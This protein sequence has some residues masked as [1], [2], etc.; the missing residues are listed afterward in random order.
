MKR[1]KQFIRIRGI[2]HSFNSIYNEINEYNTTFWS[3]FLFIFWLTFGSLDVLILYLFCFA[4]FPIIIKLFFFYSFVFFGLCFLFVIFTASSVNYTAN[5]THK[6]LNSF[7]ISYSQY[8]RNHNF[9]EIS[10]KLKVILF[11]ITEIAHFLI[12]LF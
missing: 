7:L 5:K 6:I 8:I 4:S 9:I 10:T 1:R 12:V 11:L 3:K 2:L